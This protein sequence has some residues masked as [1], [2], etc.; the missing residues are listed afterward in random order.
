MSVT[1]KAVLFADADPASVAGHSP[2]WRGTLQKLSGPLAK[3]SAAA[4]ASVERELSAVLSRLLEQDLGQVVVAGLRHHPA[5]HRAAAATEADPAAVEVVQLAANQITN[6]HHP[7]VDI[8]IDGAKLATVQFDLDLTFDVD[9][10]VGTVRQARLVNIQSGHCTVTVA[11][12][13][14]RQLIASRQAQ[15]DL[16]VTVP[17]GDGIDLLADQRRPAPA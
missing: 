4:K 12:G 14:E 15:L 16:A 13:A 5:L 2:G 7:Y 17:V 10:L 1:A 3:V 8:V 9:M 6:S 11:L